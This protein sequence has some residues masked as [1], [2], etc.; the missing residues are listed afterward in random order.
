[1]ELEA[2]DSRGWGQGPA[3]S[4]C[5][6]VTW[7]RFLGPEPAPPVPFPHP[8]FPPPPPPPRTTPTPRTAAPPGG[9]WKEVVKGVGYRKWRAGPAWGSWGVEWCEKGVSKVSFASASAVAGSWG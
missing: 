7:R 8:L 1:M 2:T 3:E 6:V 9:G 5:V 4:F